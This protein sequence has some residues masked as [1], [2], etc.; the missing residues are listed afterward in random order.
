MKA[1]SVIEFLELVKDSVFGTFYRGHTE[2]EW[3]LS[4][5]LAR[6]DVASIKILYSG[7][8]DIETAILDE[9]QKYSTLYMS[10][11]PASKLEWM[12]HAQHYGVP[13]R[14]LDWTT[15]PLKALFFAVLDSNKYNIDGAVFSLTPGEHFSSSKYMDDNVKTLTAFHPIHINERII[16]QEGSFT[17]F[18]LPQGRDKFFSLCEG[19]RPSEEVIDLNK[20]II[21][22]E[23]KNKIVDELNKLGISYQSMFPGL[24]G[25]AKNIRKKYCAV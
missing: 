7:W 25:I 10:T 18:P 6:L 20:I 3:T 9:F 2:S 11:K 5:S 22:K 21:P 24:D 13:T 12:I 23:S 1:E 17:I 15:N 4:P 19:L 8:P 16:A 14:L